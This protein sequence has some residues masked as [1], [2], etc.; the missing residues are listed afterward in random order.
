[1]ALLRIENLCV[2]VENKQIIK[3]LNMQIHPG[4]VHALMGPNGSGKS[5]LA[6]TLAGH[7]GYRV[8]DGTIRLCDQEITQ[9]PPDKRAQHGLLL[10]MQQP[11]AIPGVSIFTF[12]KESYQ[13][14]FKTQIAAPEFEKLLHEK[15][16]LLSIDQQFANRAINDG[17]SG[18]EKKRF[19]MLQVLLLQ[20]KLVILDEIDSG[21]DVDALHIV[22]SALRTL[23][24]ENPT[25][26]I[27]IIT[28][29]N[30]ILEYIE[31]DV[32][33]L[34]NQGTIVRSS[35]LQLALDIEKH[36]YAQR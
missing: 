26:S 25:I 7:P 9:L 15:M 19:E 3:N 13:A 1:M 30:R 6:F 2:S 18:G 8:T 21:L 35:G 31:P 32:V 23:K 22:G 14:I 4:S 34:F 27:I 36:G 11:L 33:H 29:Y 28:H 10:V 20:P 24:A 16:A 17:F 12:L 5:T